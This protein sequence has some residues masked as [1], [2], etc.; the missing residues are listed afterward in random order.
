[1]RDS[2]RGRRRLVCR[3]CRTSPPKPSNSDPVLLRWRDEPDAV[4]GRRGSPQLPAVSRI[5]RG[6]GVPPFPG[7]LFLS[8]IRS[9]AWPSAG[10]PA[11]AA[12]PR[13]ARAR[14]AARAPRRAPRRGTPCAARA[15]PRPRC[16]RAG[17]RGAPPATPGSPAG[18]R[19]DAPRALA[20]QPDVQPRRR[21]SRRTARRR[22]SRPARGRGSPTRSR[23]RCRERSTAFWR[24]SGQH[25]GDHPEAEPNTTR[26]SD[27]TGREVVSSMR[28]SSSRPTAISA[29][30]AIG[31][32]L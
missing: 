30:P 20:R 8:V 13:A 27:A 23:S 6:S 10:R 12:A 7:P 21:R 5:A 28:D 3:F 24:A 18:A 9:P 2:L 4:L 25:L 29:S 11:R 32:R 16:R 22:P 1:M 31:K 17:R 26:K 19:V 14:P 15:R